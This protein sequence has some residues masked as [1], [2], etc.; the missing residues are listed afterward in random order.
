[1]AQTST[2]SGVP[3]KNNH[4]FMGLAG[5][6]VVK[7]LPSSAGDMVGI[8]GRGTKIPH[9]EEDLRLRAPTTETPMCRNKASA[10]HS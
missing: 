3:V 2:E 5:G 8:P 4:T 6:P 1:M 10:C 7:N 9:A